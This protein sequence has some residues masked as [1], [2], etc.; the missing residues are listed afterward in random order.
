MLIF[1]ARFCS[2]HQRCEDDDDKLDN[3][4]D[5]NLPSLL[6]DTIYKVSL[7]TLLKLIFNCLVCI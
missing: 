4:L 3:Y 2:K 7:L 6:K 1:V 5:P